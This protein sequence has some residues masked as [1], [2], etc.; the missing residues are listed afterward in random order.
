MAKTTRKPVTT[1]EKMTDGSLY[2][3]LTDD[4]KYRVFAMPTD[5]STTITFN[6]AAKAVKKLNADRALGH[7]DWQIPT[8]EQLKVLIENKDKGALKGTFSKAA[9][10]GPDYSEWYWSSTEYRDDAVFVRSVRP[11][12]GNASW[13]YKVRLRLNCRPVRLVAAASPSL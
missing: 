2:A 11:S 12:A 6:N 4:G 5:L 13:G 1:G 10:S 7:A 8:R 3:G 9:G